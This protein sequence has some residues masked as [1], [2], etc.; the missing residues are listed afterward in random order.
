M[1]LAAFQFIY[2]RRNAPTAPDDKAKLSIK[3]FHAEKDMT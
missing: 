2:V 1:A 3:I